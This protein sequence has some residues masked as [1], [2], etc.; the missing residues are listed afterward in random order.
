MK[1]LTNK[2]YCLIFESNA[3]TKM[4]LIR[5][6]NLLYHR[7]NNIVMKIKTGAVYMNFLNQ[8]SLLNV[9]NRDLIKKFKRVFI[10]GKL[11]KIKLIF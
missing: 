1:K 10:F 9:R 11:I 2:I 3:L 8:L 4:N 7:T 6:P 5:S